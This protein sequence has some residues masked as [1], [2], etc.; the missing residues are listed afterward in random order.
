MYVFGKVSVFLFLMVCPNCDA[1]NMVGRRVSGAPVPQKTD[2]E[3]TP[4]G[5]WQG[6]KIRWMMI[7]DVLNTKCNTSFIS[8]GRRIFAPVSD[9]GLTV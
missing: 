7:F 9:S 5:T 4:V 8:R 1:R 3:P 6:N 2:S